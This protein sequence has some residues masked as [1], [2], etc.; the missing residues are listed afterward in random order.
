[1]A[2]TTRTAQIM[3]LPPTVADGPPQVLMDDGGIWR[4][5]ALPQGD[6]AGQSEMRRKI[7]LHLKT[8][9]DLVD[10][11][12]PVLPDAAG[13]KTQL[14]ALYQE[15]LPIE[16]REELKKLADSAQAGD[17]PLLKLFLTPGAEWIPWELLH[18]GT[19]FL[20]LR[21]MIARLPIVRQATEVKGPRTRKVESVFSLLGKDILQNP[22][23]VEW[24][25]IFSGFS[26]LSTWERRYPPSSNGA[27][28]PTL[29]R[30]DEARGADVVH[31]T[32]HGGLKDGNEY[33]WTLDHNNQIFTDYRITETVARNATL[34]RRP[35][36]FGN[37]CASTATQSQNRGALYG[38]GANFMIGGALNFVGTFAP[39]TKT[40]AVE[41]A[42]RF[43]VQLFGNG[44]ALR[45]PI[46]QALWAT[47]RSFMEQGCTDPSYLFYCLYG[48]PDVT[49]E[50]A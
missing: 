3:L 30:L 47:K 37:A 16:V 13:F 18:D 43:Y 20:G 33:Y 14:R 39:I 34:E 40:I 19:K 42:R 49:Y 15:L 41:F 31:V 4:D 7:E 50:P 23:F 6:V 29:D 28:Y 24:E 25:K 36:V 46:A 38:F 26:P 5:M 9:M 44:A 35:L 17:P 21:F 48:P 45:A 8:A 10:S 22:V 2:E 1:M 27:G 12:V 32:C 11:G